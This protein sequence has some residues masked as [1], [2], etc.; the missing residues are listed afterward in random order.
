MYR[1]WLLGRTDL[2]VKGWGDKVGEWWLIC[3]KF[4][5]TLEELLY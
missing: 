4:S 2:P 5:G 1:L 3:K